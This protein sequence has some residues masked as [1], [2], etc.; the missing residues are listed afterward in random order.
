MIKD[1]T[2]IVAQIR[3][4]NEQGNNIIRAIQSLTTTESDLTSMKTRIK[5]YG[6]IIQHRLDVKAT[7]SL[8]PTTT[9][10][11]LSNDI[12]V[13]QMKLDKMK[14][15]AQNSKEIVKKEGTDAIARITTQVVN[16]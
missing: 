12:K 9:S 10:V 1:S 11:T 14:L 15:F 8:T 13:I 5:A 16:L 7:T 3:K 4:E 2:T 6:N